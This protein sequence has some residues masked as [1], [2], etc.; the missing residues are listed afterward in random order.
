M[1]LNKQQSGLNQLHS[2]YNNCLTAK[3]NEWMARADDSKEQEWC[4]QEKKAYLDFMRVNLPTQ[5]ENLMR[6]EDNNF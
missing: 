3:F 2:A 1:N 6:M 5:Y 4:A